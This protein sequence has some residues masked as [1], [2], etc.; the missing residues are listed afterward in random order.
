MNWISVKE[1]HFI[2]IEIFEDG[3]YSWN[4]NNNSP[5]KPFLVGLFVNDNKTGL[6]KLE[7]WLVVLSD[8]GLE[9]RTESETYLLD[10]WEITDIEF[11][12]VI[13]DPNTAITK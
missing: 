10:S 1:K 7:Y 4:G 13:T 9:E 6:A 8:N 12:C 5:S 11:W 3:S 2:D